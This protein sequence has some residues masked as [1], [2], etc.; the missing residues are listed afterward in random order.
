MQW[1]TE[2][3]FDPLRAGEEA[4]TVVWLTT[5]TYAAIGVRGDGKGGVRIVFRRPDDSGI[6]QVRL[7]FRSDTAHSDMQETVVSRVI[8]AGEPVTLFINA[9]KHQYDFAYQV[10]TERHSCGNVPSS[11]FVPLF[12]GVHIGLYAQGANEIPCRRSAY[13]RYARWDA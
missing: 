13:F 1:S 5:T 4:G 9:T 8:A 7:H 12:T 10:K 2:V 11:A 3:T 6:L